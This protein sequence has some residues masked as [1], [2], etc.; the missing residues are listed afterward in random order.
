VGTRFVT[1]VRCGNMVTR[2]TLFPTPI[3][4]MLHALLQRHMDNRLDTTSKERWSARAQQFKH[5]S[6]LTQLVKVFLPATRGIV[7]I[8]I[9]A[10]STGSPQKKCAFH[11]HSPKLPP[12]IIQ[13]HPSKKSSE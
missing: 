2:L 12:N 6:G 13:W 4:H 1:N 5:N 3:H 10:I 11:L 9:F 7:A 8:G